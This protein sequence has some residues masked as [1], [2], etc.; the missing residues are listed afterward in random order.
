[1]NWKEEYA[2]RCKDKE[3]TKD[4]IMDSIERLK[5]DLITTFN[6][7]DV[8]LKMDISNERV[9]INERVIE[10]N[11][12]GDEFFNFYYRRNVDIPIAYEKHAQLYL[13]GEQYEYE[14]DNIERQTYF[15]DDAI[16]TIF[17]FLLSN[18]DN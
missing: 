2:L 5:K 3:L 10:L 6:K 12:Q 15:L 8:K 13:N 14:L 17:Q 7:Y 9:I 11:F 1:M 4:L 16:D 18:N